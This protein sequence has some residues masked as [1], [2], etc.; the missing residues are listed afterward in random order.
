M[1]GVSRGVLL[2]DVHR[3]D[4]AWNERIGAAGE[5]SGIDVEAGRPVTAPGAVIGMLVADLFDQ[6]ESKMIVAGTLFAYTGVSLE[7]SN[8][9]SETLVSYGGHMLAVGVLTER[10]RWEGP[11][12][13]QLARS[14]RLLAGL[15]ERVHASE[16]H[17]LGM[18]DGPS[19]A[20]CGYCREMIERLGAGGS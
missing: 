11:Q 18:H 20:G 3:A 7:F 4:T 5:G 16:D 2:G 14:A 17:G 8:D 13:D 9:F 6:A 1:T 15:L 12:D 10:Q 19:P